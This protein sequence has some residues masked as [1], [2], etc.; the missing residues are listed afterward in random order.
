MPQS[1]VWQNTKS[2]GKVGITKLWG[3]ADRLS[4]TGAAS[5]GRPGSRVSAESLW[6]GTLD[7]ESEKA[8]RILRSFCLDG[9][10]ND[11]DPGESPP[12]Q[13]TTQPQQRAQRALQRIPPEVLRHATGICV[14]TV[15]R[16][17][18]WLPSA[19]PGGSGVLLAR[20]SDGTWSP[21]SAVLVQAPGLGFLVGVDAYD[22]VLVIN[23]SAALDALSASRAG[24]SAS[25]ESQDDENGKVDGDESAEAHT[26][27]MPAPIYSYL[28]ARRNV[29]N[30]V[31]LA[32]TTVLLARADENARFYG[33]PL[34]VSD[35]LG[36]Q[37]P[38]PPT[39]RPLYDV[40][41]AVESELRSDSDT[42]KRIP[43]DCAPGECDVVPP[44]EDST[45]RP[46]TTPTLDPDPFGVLALQRAGLD[47]RESGSRK[48]PISDQFAFAPSPSSPIFP[49]Y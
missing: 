36:G 6:P 4:I 21:P 11:E 26:R 25:D 9:F 1:A 40:L 14:F 49:A 45:A 5:P 28:K 34:P 35:I 32:G 48:R 43:Q 16:G 23:D 2:S 47:I 41:K 17:P 19:G 33:L 22:V 46:P 20:L 7:K 3:W 29:I 44:G 38:L 18:L 30:D 39:L 15:L 10:Y 27:P 31:R 13:Y 8:A 12:S 37:C 24:L 42:M